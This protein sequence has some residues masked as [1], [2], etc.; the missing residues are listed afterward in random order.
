MNPF[1]EPGNPNS[2]HHI[3]LDNGISR[4]GLMIEAGL[5]SIDE[6][7]LTNNTFWNTAP[8]QFFGDYGPAFSHSQQD[9]WIGGRGYNSYHDYPD[10]YYSGSFLWTLSPGL[11]LPAPLWKWSTGA[12]RACDQHVPGSVTFIP[13]IDSVRYVATSFTAS[14]TYDAEK[15]YALVRKIGVPGNITFSIY[16]DDSGPDELLESFTQYAESG[17]VTDVVSKWL[18]VEPDATQELTSGETYWLVIGTGGDDNMMSHWEIG[19]DRDAANVRQGSDGSAWSAGTYSPYFRITDDTAEVKYTY[20][21]VVRADSTYAWMKVSNPASGASKIYSWDEDDK[22]WDLLSPAVG[23]SQPVQDLVVVNNIVFMAQGNSTGIYQLYDNA[24]TW[25]GYV[26]S[27]SEGADRLGHFVHS[28]DGDQICR[29][30]NSTFTWSRATLATAGSDLSFGDD[31]Q[32]AKG[33]KILRMSYVNKK[34]W[35]KTVTTVYTIEADTPTELKIGLD[36]VLEPEDYDA[37]M[38]PKDL[39]MIFGWSFSVERVYGASVDDIGPHRN[40]GLPEAYQGQ[41]SALAS[42]VAV[43]WQAVD[44][45][46]AGISSLYAT[47]DNGQLYHPVW[48]AWEA[49][50]R[51]RSARLQSQTDDNPRRIWISCGAD[52]V[53]IDLPDQS[54]NPDHD[55]DMEYVWEGVIETGWFPLRWS[56]PKLYKALDIISTNLGETGYVDVDYQLDDNVGSS[57]VET[58]VNIGRAQVSPFSEVNLNLGNCRNIRFRLRICGSASNTPPRIQSHILKSVARTPYTRYWTVPVLLGGEKDQRGNTEELSGKELA[59]WLYSSCQKAE[60]VRVQSMDPLLDGA[61]VMIDNPSVIRRWL[62]DQ[63]SNQRKGADV[64]GGVALAMREV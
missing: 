58:W 29:A 34:M 33:E 2:T 16:S 50:Q 23:P 11:L 25:T 6:Q 8:E 61:W 64:A 20:F 36:H 37:P 57:E 41:V 45:G 56:L 14:A 7:G 48:E 10:A 43:I 19:V 26:Q 21:Y 42:D 31:V 53:Y 63:M 46:S 24:G 28:S 35:V 17:D 32:L 40:A 47:T 60:I 1:A 44:A 30:D 51:V 27:D 12:H 22:E 3:V 5:E 62:T 38:L 49:G 13:L 9:Q 52:S 18:G 4:I 59:L 55:T 54:L 39:F 15:M